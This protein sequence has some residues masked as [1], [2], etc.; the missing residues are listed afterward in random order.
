MPVPEVE[1]LVAG[2]R[3]AHDWS[4]ARGVPAH[5]TVLYPFVEAD[6]VD[7]E[8]VDAVLAGHPAFD[9]RLARLE[10]WPGPV[11]YL[12]PEPESP[13]RALTEAI[14]GRWPEHPP[15]EGAFAD[16]IPHLTISDKADIDVSDVEAALPVDARASEVVLIEEIAEGGMWQA[17]RWYRLGAT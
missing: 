4:A 10:R 16:V 15:Y 8:A 2:Y 1:P 3:L 13:F 5:I 6:E 9:F 11:V 14:W 12:A 17:R 7:E